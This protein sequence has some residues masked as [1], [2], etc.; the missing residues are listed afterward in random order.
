MGENNRFSLPVYAHDGF[1]IIVSFGARVEVFVE[2]PYILGA[3]YTSSINLYNSGEGVLDDKVL[4]TFDREAFTPDKW[5][6]KPLPILGFT[7]DGGVYGG[8]RWIGDFYYALFTLGDKVHRYFVP[9]LDNNTNQACLY[10]AIEGKTYL[11]QGDAFTNW[12]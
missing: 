4:H 2:I 12:G 10:E 5:C 7:N 11:P 8:Y 3:P 9:V 6:N 1:R